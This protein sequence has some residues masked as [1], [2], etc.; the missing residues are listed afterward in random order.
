MTKK[1]LATVAVISFVW[2]G[3]T[4]K[5]S[6]PEASRSAEDV[7]KEFVTLSASAKNA[8]DKKTLEGLCTGEMA[9]AFEQM[10]DEQFRIFYLNG[11][12]GIQSIQVLESK[13]DG[14]AAIVRYQVTVENRQG[15]DVTKEVNDR[16]VALKLSSGNWLIDSVRAR[17]ADKLVF[18]R[19]M[20]F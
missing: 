10:T 20:I 2:G 18:T 19:G 6:I 7:V 5:A 4:K 11:N 13:V 17:G 16:E 3:C 1:I 9:K 12:L 8:V 14:E 15:T